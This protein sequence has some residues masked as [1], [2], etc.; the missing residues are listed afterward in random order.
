MKKMKLLKFYTDTCGQCK[1]LSK[2]LE[3]FDLV[4]VEPVDCGDDP[5][6][7]AVKMR[8]RNIPTLVLV[9]DEYEP[10][11]RIVGYVTKDTVEEVV[12]K[13]LDHE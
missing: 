7:L 12:K 8:V 5:D 9:N 4:P 11:H 2:E 6:N 10:I 3:G 13:Y 1:M